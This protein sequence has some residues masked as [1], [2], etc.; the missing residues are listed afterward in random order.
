MELQSLDDKAQL[1]L[2]S[3]L[4]LESL[5]ESRS[6][7]SFK[8]K[9]ESS[10]LNDAA[11]MGVNVIVD[12]KILSEIAMSP[13][14]WSLIAITGGYFFAKFILGQL[15]EVKEDSKRRESLYIQMS[16]QQLQESKKREASLI[17]LHQQHATTI[18]DMTANQKEMNETQT[19]I[20]NT[21]SKME[22]RIDSIE[23][24]LQNSIIQIQKNSFD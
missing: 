1:G 24:R 21:L 2:L 14:A 11:D 15:E 10:T 19:K 13:A 17:S 12:Y 23:N 8:E 7:K 18:K 9:K 22:K 20:V 4:P 3:I 5:K 6:P 16:E